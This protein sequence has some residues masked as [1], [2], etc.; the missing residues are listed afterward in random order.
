MIKFDLNTISEKQQRLE[1]IKTQLKIEFFGMDGIIDRAVDSLYA[2]YLFPQLITRP[3]IINLWGMTGVGKTQ[4]VRRLAQMLDYYDKYVE[5]QMDGISG[6]GGFSGSSISSIL[7]QSSIEENEPGILLL[8]EI[9]RYRTIDEHGGDT[10]VERFQDVWML[11]SDGKF[12]ADSTLFREVED[13]LAYR[14]WDADQRDTE[15]DEEDGNDLKEFL[16]S[17]KKKKRR[18]KPVHVAKFTMSPWE[19]NNLKRTLRLTEKV[20]D[21]MTWGMSQ[22]QEVLMNI[23]SHRTSWE[24]NYGKLLIF[25]SGNLDEAFSSASATEDCDTD[26]DV[27]HELTKKITT[28]DIKTALTKRFKPEQVAR[29]GN[30]HIIYPSLSKS[31]YQKLI[32]F[33]CH[34][35]LSEMSMISGIHFTLDH[36]IYKEIYDNSVYPTQG[37]RP[38]FSS[39][40]KIFSSALSNISVWA[41]QKGYDDIMISINADEL[42]LLGISV[43]NGDYTEVEI[44]LDLKKN[45]ARNSQD[46]NTL[47]AVHESGHALAHAVFTGVIPMEVKINL[48]SFRGGFMVNNRKHNLHS[49]TRHRDIIAICM[50]GAAAEE[51]VFGK[52]KRS[53]GCYNDFKTATQ[54][55]SSYVRAYGFGS[56]MSHVN[57]ENGDETFWNTDTEGT[58]EAINTICKEEY[59]RVLQMLNKHR[60]EFELLVNSLL[61]NKTLDA[62]AFQTLLGGY[63][64]L[65]MEDTE[66]SYENDWKKFTGDDK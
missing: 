63:L 10:K 38:V 46:F 34:K 21:I 4:L 2:W 20:E 51:F 59:D 8:D 27:Y 52:D 1:D 9:Q 57:G 65:S 14:M 35:Y 25:I 56:R 60:S 29:F 23:R 22:V 37:T 17:S 7:R 53:N 5:V 19:A 64:D 55:A 58:N 50:A 36:Q 16:A 66:E 54:D 28:T 42:R 44:D 43:S 49:K 61:T 18:K 32:E 45:R 26:A 41:V 62:E 31:S 48:A 47:V 12:S 11:L 13:M 6:G 40:H 30:N 15:E 39:V 33:T 3:V 24:L